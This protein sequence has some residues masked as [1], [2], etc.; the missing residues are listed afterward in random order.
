MKP[1]KK[2]LHALVII[3]VLIIYIPLVAASDFYF[4]KYDVNNGLPD[5]SVQ[6]TF[7][8]S[9]GFMWFTTQRGVVR[10]DGLNFKPLRC[11]SS[12]ALDKALLGTFYEVTEDRENRLWLGYSEGMLIYD[13]RHESIIHFND[14][15]KGD[16]KIKDE[17]KHIVVENDSLIWF[18]C[19]DKG[20][21][22]FNY[23]T[24]EL[25]QYFKNIEDDKSL[26][27]SRV[28]GLYIDSQN[29]VWLAT[30]SGLIR[31]ERNKGEFTLYTNNKD[32]SKSLC[33]NDV[34]Q[35]FEDS[36]GNLWIGTYRNGISRMNR[37]DGTFQSFLQ[38]GEK[39][40][41][42]H[43]NDINEYTPGELLIT[44]DNG[45]TSFSLSTG[46]V[47][48]R[49][50]ESIGRFNSRDKFLYHTFV[51][52]EKGLWISTYNQGVNYYSPYFNRLTHRIKSD[53]GKLIVC[54]TE[55]ENGNLWIGTED[56]GLTVY[57]PVAEK[58]DDNKF[59]FM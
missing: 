45:L 37:F 34:N 23:K 6:K 53:G 33:G 35:I 7:Q 25:V 4:R 48:N 24:N 8:D 1:A 38:P 14:L 29:V 16:I 44:S 17:V 36:Q 55:D 43:L 13:F 42:L 51:D 5:N 12:Q 3:V 20:F 15:V 19:K 54:A 18:T 26:P 47:E 52:R 2:I 39:G 41:P 22:K 46:L 49:V 50:I 27:I 32:D 21:C 57:D 11:G 10:F 31:F 30:F 58:F 59:S 40:Y 9:R 28:V 56:G